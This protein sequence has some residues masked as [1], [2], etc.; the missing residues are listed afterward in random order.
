MERTEKIKSKNT[1]TR[2]I[3]QKSRERT[4]DGEVKS[5]PPQEKTLKHRAQEE[6][7]NGQKSKR[8]VGLCRPRNRRGTMEPLRRIDKR[9]Q[10]PRAVGQMGCSQAERPKA[11]KFIN[12]PKKKTP[13]N[14]KKEKRKRSR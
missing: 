2:V 14:Q 7:R 5:A 11:P 3:A 12:S 10:T 4:R 9:I 1:R 13:K 6:R 8:N